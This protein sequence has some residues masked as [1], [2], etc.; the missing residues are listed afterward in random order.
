VS[1][2]A[3]NHAFSQIAPGASAA[4]LSG[5]TADFQIEARAMAPCAYA[6]AIKRCAKRVASL[7]LNRFP[8][9]PGRFT[10]D[11]RPIFQKLR[12]VMGRAVGEL[13]SAVHSLSYATIRP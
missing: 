7:V 3:Q 6:T 13:A 10:L 1:Q 9:N 8:A 12:I 5:D 4:F 11:R 2:R